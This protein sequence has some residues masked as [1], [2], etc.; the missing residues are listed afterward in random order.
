M[1]SAKQ[2]FFFFL[3]LAKQGGKL[4]CNHI[5]SVCIPLTQLTGI[6]RPSLLSNEC[7]WSRFAHWASRCF[8]AQLSPRYLHQWWWLIAAKLP[9]IRAHILCCCREMSLK[10]ETIWC[11]FRCLHTSQNLQAKT[12]KSMHAHFALIANNRG[13]CTG[14]G[15]NQG[16][17]W[18]DIQVAVIRPRPAAVS[19]V[20]SPRLPLLLFTGF[21]SF[22][23]NFCHYLFNLMFLPMFKEHYCSFFCEASCLKLQKECKNTL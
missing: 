8:P 6:D 23:S 11:L 19:P 10:V 1:P 22:S 7:L 2:L 9:C 20:L 3:F 21:F 15:L 16:M 4:R 17:H 12:Q 13:C 18:G 5:N 14:S